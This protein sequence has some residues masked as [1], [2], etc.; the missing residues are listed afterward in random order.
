[1]H[2][3]SESGE[4]SVEELRERVS[5]RFRSVGAAAGALE[6]KVRHATDVRGVARRHPVWVL[7]AV[8]G[9][10]LL[11]AGLVRRGR[12]RRAD[13]I[14]EALLGPGRAPGPRRSGVL[15]AVGAPAVRGAASL[16]AGVL[17]RRLGRRLQED[18][19]PKPRLVTPRRAQA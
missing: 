3:R 5:A 9:A 12:P 4:P 7:A 6:A 10:G 8:A 2:V 14:A 18:L 13:T 16:L 19:R 1:M 11:A 15:A 17:V